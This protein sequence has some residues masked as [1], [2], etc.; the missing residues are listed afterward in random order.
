MM[1]DYSV[2]PCNSGMLSENVRKSYSREASLEGKKEHLS[3][4]EHADYSDS[5]P[6]HFKLRYLTWKNSGYFM[7]TA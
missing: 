3:V 5:V 2:P 6:K 7:R 1:P 4:T